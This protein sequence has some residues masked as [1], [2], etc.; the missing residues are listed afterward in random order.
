MNNPIKHLQNDP[1]MAE[2]INRFGI[3]KITTSKK[4]YEEIVSSIVS[5]Q[6][7]V[8]AA[9]TIWNRFID[10]FPE[11]QVT[12]D[13]VDL[14][15][16]EIIRGVGISYAKGRY[17]KDLSEKILKNEI[18]LN[19]LTTL[20]DEDVVDYLTKVKGIGRWT[21]QMILMFTL[22]RKN[23]FPTDDLGIQTAISNLYKTPKGDKNEMMRLSESWS[24][25]KTLACKYL[26]KS[27]DNKV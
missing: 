11:R 15:D 4:I 1:V 21:A 22:G 7:S 9:S 12:P 13:Y 8:K 27:L 14:L 20:S 16:I 3:L 18:Q 26:W 10:L 25:F 5:Q 17:I 19:K 2:L 24:P 23:I 6:L